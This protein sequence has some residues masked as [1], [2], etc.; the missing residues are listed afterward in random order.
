MLKLLRK[1]WNGKV[2]LEQGH[3]KLSKINV[4]NSLVLNFIG[5]R[6]GNPM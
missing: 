1:I 3:N 5:V 4:C 6:T 2:I